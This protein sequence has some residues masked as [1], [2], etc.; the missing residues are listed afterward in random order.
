MIEVYFQQGYS[1]VS[2]RLMVIQLGFSW[3]LFQGELIC[4]S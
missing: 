2:S 4:Y 1:Q 3:G